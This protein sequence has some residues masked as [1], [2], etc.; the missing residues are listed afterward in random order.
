MR[1]R[2]RRE[3]YS[4]KISYKRCLVQSLVPHF[5]HLCRPQKQGNIYCLC[6][7]RALTI[8]AC[9][10]VDGVGLW[11]HWRMNC[12]LFSATIIPTKAPA[13]CML[14]FTWGRTEKLCFGSQCVWELVLWI[15]TE[16]GLYL[17]S[18][19][20]D[21]DGYCKCS[22]FLLSHQRPLLRCS[23][24]IP[25][26]RKREKLQLQS[27]LSRVEPAWLVCQKKK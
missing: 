11:I 4:F 5:S 14:W 13:G 8:S 6:W 26:Q 3:R 19:Y 18:S 12:K 21:H 2:G 15:E 20:P 16:G 23:R 22:C 17:P 10:L 9:V 27:Q 25:Q 1:R 24:C 7:D